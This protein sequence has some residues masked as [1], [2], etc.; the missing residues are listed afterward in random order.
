M[1][2]VFLRDCLGCLQVSLK[3]S[4]TLVKRTK[5]LYLLLAKELFGL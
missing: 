2:L 3:A 1:T 4:A 5:F